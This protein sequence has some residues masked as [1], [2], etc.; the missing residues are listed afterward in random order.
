MTTTIT[1]ISDPGHGWLAVPLAD[2]LRL[3]IEPSEYSFISDDGQTAYLEEDC[4]A[5]LFIDASGIDPSLIRYEHVD[6]FER[7]ARRFP[8]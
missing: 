1:F 5:S 3:G 4:D 6:D 2:V 7:P 8:A